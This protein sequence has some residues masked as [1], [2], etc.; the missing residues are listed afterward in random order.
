[1]HMTVSR[2]QVVAGA[3]VTSF[4]FVL[5]GAVGSVFGGTA[6]AAGSKKFAGY[7]ELIPD[8]AGVVDLPKGFRYKV[9]S[10]AGVDKLSTGEPV[11]GVP[12]GMRAF[13]LGHG[14][15]TLVRNH[16]LE[17]EDI[18]PESPKVPHHAGIVYDP[19]APGGT[20]TLVVQDGKLLSHVPSIAGTVRNCAGGG[21]PWGTWLTCEE[22]ED[23]PEDVPGLTKRHGYVFEVDP[24]GRLKDP[25]V[26]L[27]A[28]GRYAHEAAAVNPKTGIVYLTEDASEPYGL[29]YRLLPKK[30]HGG[31]G[32]LRAGGK[33]QALKA[34]GVPDL[35]AVTKLYTKL[36]V[37]WVD[38]PDPDAAKTSVR[39]QFDGGKV[40]RIPK[41][42]GIYWA[43]GSAYV[44]SS[45]AKTADGA[46][47]D[48]VG[49]VWRLDPWK[50][51]IELLLLLK[52]GGRFDSPDNITV[53]SYGPI[54]LCED[55]EGESHLIVVGPD[56]T[57]YPLARNALGD[58]EWAGATFSPNGKW[59]YANI[60]AD[61]LTVA[62]TGPWWQH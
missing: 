22:T 16:E 32:S 50:E 38:V 28:L 21:T 8:P 7:G 37:S 58:S 51:T 10:R 42:E 30:P 44:V 3:G 2:R 55:G 48:H 53:S 60:Q 36:P 54:V 17:S 29:L 31:P 27:K 49:Q 62:I 34:A 5:S 20:T 47:A 23:T 1:M 45:F 41:A 46:A 25:A 12:D 43:R 9:V 26:P 6:A 56:S 19:G 24:F 59:L 61:G 52:P 4:G 40:T 35:S 13:P 33:L 11:P 57:P 39:E 15:D 14:K 18:S